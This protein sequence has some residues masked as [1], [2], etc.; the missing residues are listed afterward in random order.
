VGRTGK[1]TPVAEL[2]PIDLAGST[3]SRATLNNFDYIREQGMCC[4]CGGL[5]LLVLFAN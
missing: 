3:I 1:V 2:E 5:L 4:E